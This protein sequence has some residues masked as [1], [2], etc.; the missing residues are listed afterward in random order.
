MNDLAV[1]AEHLTKWYRIGVRERMHDSLSQAVFD[2]VRSPIRNYRKYRSLYRFDDLFPDSGEGGG[3]VPKD[4]IWALRDVSFEVKRGEVLGIIGRN[5]AGKSTLLKVLSRITDP[6]RGRAVIRGRS[7]C[8]LE[9]GTGFH[10]ELTGRENIYLNGTILGMRKREIDAKLDEIV[11]FSGVERF[12]ET[13]VKRYSSGMKVR[14]AF[15][16]AAH[17]EPEILIIDEVLAVGDAA[18]QKKCLGKME[19]VAR[20]GRTVLFV[21]HD[22]TA[23]QSLCSRCLLMHE[24]QIVADG[25]MASTM[26]AYLSSVQQLVTEQALGDR[27]DRQG[28]HEF[29]FLQIDFLDA[30]SGVPAASLMSGQSIRA[31]LVY[32]YNGEKPL[33]DVDVTISFWRPPG[34]FLFAC[35]SDAKG[36]LFRVAPGEGVINCSIPRLPLSGGR[37]SFNVFAR[38]RGATLDY[39]QDAGVLEVEAGDF[40]GSGKIPTPDQQGVL[41]DFDWSHEASVLVVD[42]PHRDQ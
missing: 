25:S 15:A 42:G 24:G 9:V 6:S 21:S 1:S 3:A 41:V 27:Q 22:M 34:A 18:F 36:R 38:S 28:G 30:T 11:D 39:I 7:A 19:R 29:R 20:E 2:F 13:P 23:I 17:L 31:R 32:R 12:I 40:Y 37:Y 26:D 35:A 5:G 10:P 33:D 8:L 4:V 16:V 14:L